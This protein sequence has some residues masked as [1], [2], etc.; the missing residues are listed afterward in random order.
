MA[1]DD[2]PLSA[3]QAQRYDGLCETR[4]SGMPVAYLLGYAGFYGREFLVNER[5]LIPR[6]ETEHLVE[7]AI[8]HARGILAGDAKE[9]VVRVFEAGVGSGAI[10]CSVA[11]EVPAA[12][13]EGTDLSEHV[14][15]IAQRNARCFGVHARC[16]FRRADVVPCGAAT[17]YDIVIANLPYIPSAD[18]PCKPDPVA[19][20]PRVALDGGADGLE[21]YRK[22]LGAVPS[23][24][25]PGGLLLMEAAPPTLPALAAL[26]RAALPHASIAVNRDYAGQERYVR[27]AV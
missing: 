22:L 3:T 19:F 7:D 11:A 20:E 2:M 10:A 24:L 4:A 8:A 1:H 9:T 21:H 13:V 15:E 17:A 5:V 12:I 16:R 14:L 6:P 18:I 25:R 23:M 26:T 27:A